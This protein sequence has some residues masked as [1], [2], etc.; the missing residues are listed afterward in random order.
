[1]HAG[2]LR[3]GRARAPT[4][5]HE[6]VAEVE[7]ARAPPITRTALVARA[8]QISEPLLW[9]AHA[10]E[11]RQ[12]RGP[13]RRDAPSGCSSCGKFRIQRR[14]G[15]L[16][17][18]EIC[19]KEQSKAAHAWPR[20]GHSRFAFTWIRDSRLWLHFQMVFMARTEWRAPKSVPKSVRILIPTIVELFFY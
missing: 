10:S 20:I 4:G 3:P 9:N 6:R 19:R 5:A 16:R 17:P 11:R 13:W 8:Y 12:R 1:M 18:Q 14:A 15:L 2:A 7:S